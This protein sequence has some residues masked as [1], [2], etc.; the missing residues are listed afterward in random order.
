MNLRETSSLISLP[1]KGRLPDYMIIG[2]QRGGTTSLFHYLSEN[3]S[4]SSPREKELHF[5]SEK[6]E[7]GISWYKSRFPTK[8]RTITGES[9]PYY[10]FHPLCA[11]RI[12]KHVPDARLVLMLRNPVTR[13]YSNYWL[14]VEHGRENLSFE[15]ALKAEEERT[16]G[17]EEK[18]VK[19]ENYNSEK[20]RLYSYVARGR[21]IE[22][23]ERYMKFF[24]KEK[25]LFLRS[26][27][28]FKD[29]LAT[30]KQTLNFLD[31]PLEEMKEL[32]QHNAIDYPKMKA[33]TKKSLSEYFK[34][35]NEKLYS[36][37][38]IDFG[39]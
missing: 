3:T 30:T 8:K 39:W 35:Y 28:F 34:P 1:R 17:E 25:F 18:I 29:P 12:A 11:E 10:L 16:K 6:Y 33:E 7:K 15:E 32:K 2:T 9:T 14:V 26:E 21:Y 4:V 24:P 19:N 38:G 27:D 13:A 22:Q 36:Y 37:L 23:I 5:F 31:L 20:H